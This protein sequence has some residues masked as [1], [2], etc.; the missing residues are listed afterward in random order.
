M[1][2]TVARVFFTRWCSSRISRLWRSSARRRSVTSA[3]TPIR[4]RGSRSG[5]SRSKRPAKSMV[6]H[7]PSTARRMRPLT[8][9][10][11][12]LAQ[13]RARSP[14]RKAGPVVR[15][16]DVVE[17]LALAD[18]A[19]LGRC[20]R[21]SRTCA[22]S[23]RSPGRRACA[24]RRCRARRGRWRCAGAARG[25]AG[26]SRA[27]TRVGDVLNHADHRRSRRA[28]RRR[29]RPARAP[30][31][32]RGASA[33]PCAGGIRRRRAAPRRGGLA[34]AGLEAA[35]LAGSI[36]RAARPTAAAWPGGMAEDVGGAARQGRRRPSARSQRHSPRPG[37]GRARRGS[38]SAR[39]TSSASTASTTRTGSRR[40][41]RRR[42]H[43]QPGPRPVRPAPGPD[44][45]RARMRRRRRRPSRRAGRGGRRRAIAEKVAEM[46]GWPRR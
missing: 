21:R 37:G 41:P 1:A 25:R 32:R 34:H 4:R 14:A 11:A 7:A 26:A 30:R 20:A 36:R 39:T 46:R 9:R 2:W 6:R 16:E 15:V 13:G 38:A 17:E 18:G 8:C 29:G 24:T 3:T 33:L 42:P 43:A 27:S 23:P 45:A 12:V 19:V 28:I 31:R 10:I 44:A 22:R 35:G 40:A 5:A